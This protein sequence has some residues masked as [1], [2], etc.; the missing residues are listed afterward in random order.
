M[1]LRR[2][3]AP[4]REDENARAALEDVIREGLVIRNREVEFEHAAHA[5]DL[6][7]WLTYRAEAT[8][9]SILRP[10]VVEHPRA[11]LALEGGEILMVGPGR[12]TRP[13]KH[14]RHTFGA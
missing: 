8:N 3:A 5:S 6:E 1:T 13:R 14:V 4:D 9:H 12:A 7:S 11:L 2:I 10:E